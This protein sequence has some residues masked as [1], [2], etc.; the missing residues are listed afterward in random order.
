M[1]M[2]YTYADA[3]LAP[4]VGQA[5]EAQAIADV[6]QLGTL[7]AAYVARLVA[8]RAYVLTC[9]E[10]QKAPDD[11]FAAK[12]AAY[13]KEWAD[14]LAQARAAQDALDAASGSASGGASPF[15]VEL[16]RS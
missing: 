14:V 8:V 7:P 9:L 1:A 13:R 11:L 4:L 2:T 6:A 15:T 3:Y 5:R 12:L 16:V 10:S